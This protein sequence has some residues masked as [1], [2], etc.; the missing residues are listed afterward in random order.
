MTLLL[1]F[2]ALTAWGQDEPSPM[3]FDD[4]E[5]E[6]VEAMPAPAVEARV[7]KQ[8]VAIEM[9]TD[10]A[11]SGQMDG[12]RKSELLLRLAHLMHKQGRDT[13]DPDLVRQAAKVYAQ[14]LKGYPNNPRMDHVLFYLGFSLHSVG[15]SGAE[16][17]LMRV[18]EQYPSSE[19][20]PHAML[21][22]G[23]A[24]FARQDYGAAYARYEQSSRHSFEFSDFALYKAAWSLR[25]SGDTTSAIQTMTAALEVAR[26]GLR[27]EAL[28]AL[29]Y[30]AKESGVA[31]DPNLGMEV[32]VRL[33]GNCLDQLPDYEQRL[34]EDPMGS[35]A[36]S[37]QFA[38]VR[39]MRDVGESHL[40]ALRA[41]EGRFGKGTRWYKLQ[42]RA[43]RRQSRKLIRE[44]RGW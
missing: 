6:A 16:A 36:V 28:L 2:F 5:A 30:W 20:V 38:I 8:R 34:A 19:Y 33:H 4:F 22:S 9:L 12:E 14:I 25:R 37:F 10:L 3:S 35:G 29:R 1:L 7:A 40:S 24:S 18:P 11:S 43:T 13:K 26:P 17:L 31:L 44:A 32:V 15:E 41:L 27:G 42:E 23:E 39:C 21:H